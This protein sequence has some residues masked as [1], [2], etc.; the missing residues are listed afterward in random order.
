MMMQFSELTPD[1]AAKPAGLRDRLS[2][3]QEK[4]RDQFD[5]LAA[6]RD[7]WI[8]LNRYFYES[9]RAYMR[10]LVPPNKTVLEVGSGTGELLAALQPTRGVGIDLSAA[11]VGI[12]R[13]NHP[14][15]EFHAGN[16]ED[17]EL[18]AGI[19]GPFDFI[20]LSDTIGYFEDCQKL[21]AAL[22]SLA[23]NHTRIII[24]Y[25]SPLWIPL[26]RLGEQVGQKMPHSN[27]NW[28]STGDTVNLLG[29]A[30][31][32][33]VSREWRQLLPKRLAGLGTLVNRSL[34]PLPG[35]RRLC[36]RNYIVGRPMPRP[37]SA[38]RLPSAT[39]VIPCRNERGNIAAAIER[40]PRFCADL[41]VIFVEGHSSDGTYDEC[42][43]VQAAHPD[44]DIKVFRQDGKGKGDAVRKGFAEARGDIL[45][46]L[47]ADLT[48]PPEN[49][50]KFYEVLATR[51]AEF[52]S[53]TRLVYPMA[54]GAMRFLNL[55]G[56]RFFAAVF[57]FLLNQRFTDTLCGTK[58]LWR[59]DYAE[60]VKSRSY[61]GD[62]DPFGDFDL[63]FGASK[64]NLKMVEIPV[65][66][67][68][69][70]YGTTQ[71]S[72]FSHGWLLLRMTAFAWRKLKA[73]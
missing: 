9:D 47:D 44:L 14:E 56:N 21:L 52:A 58:A 54:E 5:A 17:P 34:A 31:Y 64:L 11:M 65:R 25:Y 63:M 66:Y 55:L 23:A 20:I 61:F 10:F 27:E 29:L 36:L 16:A 18:L 4:I 26:L 42:L 38:A 48:V 49:L 8:A 68:D 60:L 39:V 37:E 15:L 40:L 62:F 45:I 32:E 67:F 2:A 1:I 6:D 69:R 30:G 33:V 12:A 53:G 59:N 35:I 3:R 73:F 72:R 51:K 70:S 7:R 46:I 24:A 50:P 22:Q 43:R 71:I 57:S 13:D 41:E 19:E 28:L